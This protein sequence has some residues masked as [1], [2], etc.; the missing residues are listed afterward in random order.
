MNIRKERVQ[1]QKNILKWKN[2]LKTLQDNC[3]HPNATKV[4]NSNTGNYDP[5]CDSYW[6]EYTCPDCNKYW[7]V[8]L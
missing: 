6:E 2:A 8:D 1:I 5:S 7:T 3:S 4:Y